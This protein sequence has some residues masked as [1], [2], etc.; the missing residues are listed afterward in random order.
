MSYYLSVV[1][2]V[3]L[4]VRIITFIAFANWK[5]NLTRIL[6]MDVN[7]RP[8]KDSSN[9]SIVLKVYTEAER[10]AKLWDW[11]LGTEQQS[12]KSI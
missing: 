12:I 3:R 10:E 1:L 9:I 4:S 5:F 2:F 7:L 11:L 8:V 6:D